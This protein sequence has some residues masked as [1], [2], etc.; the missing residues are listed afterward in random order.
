MVIN[1]EKTGAEVKKSLM[2]HSQV[3]KEL[4]PDHVTDDLLLLA[5]QQFEQE[6]NN[7]SSI[8][9]SQLTKE[10]FPDQITDDIL[11]LASQQF[12]GK[13]SPLRHTNGGP[14]PILFDGSSKKEVVVETRGVVNR[15]SS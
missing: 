1:C 8:V 5:S 11:L 14:Q 10:E 9:H 13:Q 6:L 3:A 4:F 12:E 2:I 15:G 7:C